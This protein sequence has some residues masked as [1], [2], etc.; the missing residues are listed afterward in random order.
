MQDVANPVNLPILIS[1][2]IFLCSLCTDINLLLSQFHIPPNSCCV[3][4]QT[5]I[6]VACLMPH[7]QPIDAHFS[8]ILQ[9]CH[10]GDGEASDGSA[11]SRH[12]VSPSRYY[13]SPSRNFVSSSST[14][15]KLSSSPPAIPITELIVVVIVCSSKG[16]R[17]ADNVERVL[18]SNT[19]VSVEGEGC[20]QL[21]RP[22]T[23]HVSLAS[24]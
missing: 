4:L 15:N 17:S 12:Y 18:E 11:A 8:Q 10:N 1:C 13:V 16:F 9:Q 14:T 5:T 21:R 3:K 19:T 23:R 2:R 24:V 7:D 22:C 20:I 6:F